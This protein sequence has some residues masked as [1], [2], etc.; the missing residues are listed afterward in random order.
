MPR[1]LLVKVA[2]ILVSQWPPLLDV[3]EGKEFLARISSY[4]SEGAVVL[5]ATPSKLFWSTV[6]FLF[7]ELAVGGFGMVPTA[8]IFGSASS[9]N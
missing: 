4:W 7:R 3:C 2:K 9:N 8:R 1:G 6:S 5:N